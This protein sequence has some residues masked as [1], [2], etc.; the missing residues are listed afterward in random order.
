MSQY[1]FYRFHCPF[2]G[3]I[4]TVEDAEYQGRRFD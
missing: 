4:Q 3:F 1:D 2:C